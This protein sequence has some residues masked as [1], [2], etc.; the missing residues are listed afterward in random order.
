MRAYE[1]ITENEMHAWQQNAVSGLKALADDNYY[2]LYRLGITMAGIGR[3]EDESL[4]TAKTP[5]E[6]CGL[7]LSY[8]QEDEDIINAALKKNGHAAK[9]VTPTGSREPKDTMTKSPVANLG[10]VKRKS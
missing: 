8:S 4:G 5:A 1:F 10:P 6:D 7:T 3:E 2:E 9:Q